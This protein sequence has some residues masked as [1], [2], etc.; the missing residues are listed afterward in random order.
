MPTPH[1]FTGKAVW[2]APGIMRATAD[3][4]GLSLDG[5]VDGV[6]G[7]SCADVGLSYW[8]ARSTPWGVLTWEGPFLVVDCARRGDLYGVVVNR[9]EAVEVSWDTKERWGIDAPLPVLVSKHP[10]AVTERMLLHI[11]VPS[12]ERH[13][14]ENVELYPL[15]LEVTFDPRPVF[16]APRFWRLAGVWHV[17]TLN[18]LRPLRPA[19]LDERYGLPRID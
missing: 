5:Y 11:S 8:I 15:A 6:S 2:Y 19:E 13:F 1:V 3:V 7:T 17:A 4:R 12:L 16:R 14:L 18:G 10:P 9:Q